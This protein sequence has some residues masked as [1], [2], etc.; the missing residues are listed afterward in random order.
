MIDLKPHVA[1]IILPVRAQPGARRAGITGEHSGML[2][3][4]VNAAPDKGKANQAILELLCDEL[5]LS[6]SQ[7]ELVS[8]A[9]SRTK[10]FLVC[11]ITADELA[12]RIAQRL[13]AKD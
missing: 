1:G 7:V 12:R 13:A 5:S 3:V 9:T 2:K 4:A 6:R 10:Q 8:G 11:D